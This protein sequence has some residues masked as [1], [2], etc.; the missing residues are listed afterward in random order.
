MWGWDSASDSIDVYCKEQRK[1][2]EGEDRAL[3]IN[4]S[5]VVSN[6]RKKCPF[7]AL[8]VDGNCVHDLPLT[9][10]RQILK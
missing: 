3:Y 7:L 5:P 9:C 4:V 2:E 6:I 8:M 10:H 1:G